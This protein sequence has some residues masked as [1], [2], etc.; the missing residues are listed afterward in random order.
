MAISLVLHGLV[1]FCLG[2]AGTSGPATEPGVMITYLAVPAGVPVRVPDAKTAPEKKAASKPAQVRPAFPA[3]EKSRKVKSQPVAAEATLDEKRQS[4]PVPVQ[5]VK[6]E[7][8]VATVAKVVETAF[9]DEIQDPVPAAASEIENG[10]TEPLIQNSELRTQN[11]LIP[12]SI[13]ERIKRII[14]LFG[15]VSVQRQLVVGS[16]P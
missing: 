15:S 4:E 9:P 10:Q 2:A 7:E 14:L 11:S 3:P 6:V 13:T 8:Q 5:E 1:L 16:G 12:Q